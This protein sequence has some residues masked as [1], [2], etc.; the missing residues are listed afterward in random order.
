MGKAQDITA[1]ILH[2]FITTVAILG[3]IYSIEKALYTF[4]FGCLM[5]LWGYRSGS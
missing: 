3:M 2:I 4:M 5:W 1:N